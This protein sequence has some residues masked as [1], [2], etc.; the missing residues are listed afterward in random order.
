M[1]GRPRAPATLRKRWARW[2]A[3]VE[4]FARRSRARR[5]VDPAAY[6]VL[7][8]ELIDACR[9]LAES[10]DEDGRAYYRGLEW[11]VAPWLSPGRW[12]RPTARSSPASWPAAT[13]SMGNSAREARPPIPSRSSSNVPS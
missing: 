4:L 9:A 7:H 10:A 1:H 3:I 12:R 2:A 8:R 6:Q 5:H 11:I 13:R